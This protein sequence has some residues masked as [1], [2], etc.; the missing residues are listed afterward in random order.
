MEVSVDELLLKIGLLVVE[1]DKLRAAGK[2]VEAERNSLKFAVS[3][4]EEEVV[5]LRAKCGEGCGTEL[6]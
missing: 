5:R 4:A 1:N 3:K 2:K 6:T